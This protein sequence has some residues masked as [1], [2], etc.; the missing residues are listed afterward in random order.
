MN[1]VTIEI[2]DDKVFN[3]LQHLEYMNMLRIVK[4]DNESVF[5]GKKLS[6]RFAGCISNEKA[7]ELQ[8]ELLQMRKEWERDIF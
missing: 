8:K 4:S 5:Y 2:K 1:T 7:E 3:F 6:E